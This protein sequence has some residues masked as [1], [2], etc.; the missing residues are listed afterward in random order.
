V[1]IEPLS[2]QNPLVRW[3]ARYD[4]KNTLE[5]WRLMRNLLLVLVPVA[6]PVAVIGVIL[7]NL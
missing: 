1:E 2:Y 4:N 3:I 5:K 6:I 7:V